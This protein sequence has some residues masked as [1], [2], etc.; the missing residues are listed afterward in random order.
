M[1]SIIMNFKSINPYNGK[2]VGEYSAISEMELKDKLAK[3]QIVFESWRK[4]SLSERC[5]LLKNAGQVLRDNLEEYALM[6]T[7]E[8]GKAIKE[9]RSEI[10]K[11]AWVCD[12][13]AENAEAFLVNEI[14]CYRCCQKFCTA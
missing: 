7:L 9:S 1:D 14:D 4:V 10:N 2:V 11:C 5:R 6:I 13:Y 12:Y 8:M 3:S